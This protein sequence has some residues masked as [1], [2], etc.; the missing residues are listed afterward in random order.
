M[1]RIVQQ[2]RYIFNTREN[3]C[4]KNIF[5]YIYEYNHSRQ[6]CQKGMFCSKME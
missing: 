1:K 4:E 5:E 2:L 6:S 3:Q